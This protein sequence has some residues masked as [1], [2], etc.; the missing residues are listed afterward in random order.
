M[1]R[2]KTPKRPD[3]PIPADFPLEQSVGAAVRFTYRQ[4]IYELQ[5]EL[6]PHDISTG[7]WFFLRVLWDEE[8]LTQR[9]LGERAGTLDAATVEQLLSMQSRGLIERRR[10]PHDQRKMHVFLTAR[11]RALKRTLA[12]IAP[13]INNIALEGLSEGE[14]GFLRLALARIRKNLSEHRR[15]RAV[16]QGQP[17]RIKEP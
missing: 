14:I 16:N 3:L 9:E 15:A 17:R 6:A 7:M 1:K 8:G 4:F 5:D 10:S 11:G 13:D 12:N 2:Q